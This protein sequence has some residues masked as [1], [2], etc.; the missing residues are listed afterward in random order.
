MRGNEENKKARGESFSTLPSPAWTS[1]KQSSLWSPHRL[2]TTS[3]IAPNHLP[4]KSAP[5]ALHRQY[6]AGTLRQGLLG[7][8]A[9]CDIIKSQEN[10]V[11]REGVTKQHCDPADL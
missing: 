11:Q 2:I 4:R 6:A 3:L 9:H 5:S 10:H 1:E 8:G 7:G